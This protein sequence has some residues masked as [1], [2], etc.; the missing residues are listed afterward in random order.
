MEDEDEDEMPLSLVRRRLSNV[1]LPSST[2]Q[3]P[4]PPPPQSV[5][6]E[7]RVR[8]L[9]HEIETLKRLQWETAEADRVRRFEESM[10]AKVREE[11]DKRSRDEESARRRT[12]E[13]RRWEEMR[14]RTSIIEAKEA[15]KQAE[16]ERERER[17]RNRAA[18][19]MTPVPTLA[20]GTPGVPGQWPMMAMAAPPFLIPL[21]MPPST[22]ALPPASPVPQTPRAPSRTSSLYMADVRRKSWNVSSPQ[23][24]TVRE[25]DSFS[26]PNRSGR[27]GDIYEEEEEEV[28]LNNRPTSAAASGR[29]SSLAGLRSSSTPHLT[30]H[31]G[32]VGRPGSRS[33]VQLTTPRP[34]SQDF[35]ESNHIQ[36]QAAAPSP[37]APPPPV[38]PRSQ[39]AQVRRPLSVL[40]R[41]YST[42]QAYG[43]AGASA[44]Y[45]DLRV[46]RGSSMFLQPY[47]NGGPQHPAASSH[48]RRP[49]SYQSPI[50]GR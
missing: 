24:S 41:S 3:T 6:Q 25:G 16:L 34:V 44:S 36:A 10:R 50:V 19:V 2:S 23:L 39:Q 4:P 22:P 11:R 31:L 46:R 43:H 27:E 21:A 33:S 8:H 26:S 45:D 38:R 28:I 32:G 7:A 42:P 35:T 15:E 17:E 9:E 40:P 37:R 18:A 14:R 1:P 47:L 48:Y 29:R 5:H 49:V 13:R 30:R 12:E 20:P